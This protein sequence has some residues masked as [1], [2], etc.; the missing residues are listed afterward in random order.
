MI[1]KAIAK[2]KRIGIMATTNKKRWAKFHEEQKKEAIKDFSRLKNNG[3]FIA[4]LMLYWGE[5]DNSPTSPH[6]RL[7]NTDPR[8]I[9]LFL[10]FAYQVCKI[11]KSQVRINL[12]IYPD[13]SQAQCEKFWSDYLKIP[14]RQFYKTQLIKGRHPTKRLGKGVCMVRIGS[15]NLKQKFITWIDLF[16][17]NNSAGMVQW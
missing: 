4:G 12:I 6:V 17:K 15:T 5:G 2:D 9:K 3:L 13:I 1:S 10:N 16:S 11:P 7:S 8:M 14:L